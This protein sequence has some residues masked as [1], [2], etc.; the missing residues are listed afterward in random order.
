MTL[1]EQ[2]TTSEVMLGKAVLRADEQLH[3]SRS[4]FARVLDMDVV[5]KIS[6]N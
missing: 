2:Q 5:A 6:L 3:L 1:L 4:Q